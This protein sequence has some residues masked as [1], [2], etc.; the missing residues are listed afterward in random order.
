[1]DVG[2][3]RYQG[4]EVL[5][6]LKKFS[7]TERIPLTLG[8]RP[9]LEQI[10]W[11]FDH[12]QGV[13]PEEKK[14]WI[15]REPKKVKDKDSRYKQLLSG[16]GRR[17]PAQRRVEEP[18]GVTPP[19]QQEWWDIPTLDALGRVTWQTSQPVN[20]TPNPPQQQN[21]RRTQTRRTSAPTSTPSLTWGPSSI[22]FFGDQLI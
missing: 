5:R 3:L 14:L 6:M 22:D 16:W 20:P 9:K 19:P 10:R 17:R 1:M 12:L 11:Y 21:R 18:R 8:L 7:M 4:R 15:F 13:S 2:G